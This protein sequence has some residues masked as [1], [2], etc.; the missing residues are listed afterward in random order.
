M[1]TMNAP[2]GF[3]EVPHT[4]DVALR[5]WAPDDETLFMQAALGLNAVAGARTGSQ[6]VVREITLHQADLVSLLVAFLSEL[7]FLQEHEHLAFGEFDLVVAPPDLSGTL[8][9]ADILSLERPLKAA[10]FHNLLIENT[11]RGLEAQIVF[12]V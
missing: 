10:T 2:A 1:S 4:A 7:V 12:D 3:T 8:K 6:S 9:G 11:S 5:I